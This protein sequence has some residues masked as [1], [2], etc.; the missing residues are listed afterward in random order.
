MTTHLSILVGYHPWNYSF[1]EIGIARNKEV[2]ISPHPYA[3]AFYTSSEFRIDHNKFII[4]PKIGCWAAGGSAAMA[5]GASII[6]YTDFSTSS[7]RA[8][9]EIG[10]GMDIWKV[11]WGYNIPLTNR[12]FKGINTNVASLQLLLGVKTLKETEIKE[13]WD[14]RWRNRNDSLIFFSDTLHVPDTVITKYRL[15]L[16]GGINGWRYHQFGEVGFGYYYEDEDAGLLTYVAEEVM[17]GKQLLTGTKTGAFLHGGHE[18]IFGCGLAVINYTDFSTSSWV[19]RPEMGFHYKAHRIVYGYNYAF[20]K[21]S[22][23][24]VNRN[25][26]SLILCLRVKKLKDRQVVY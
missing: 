14:P 13:D 7:L 3:D 15:M 21:H 24:S 10:M 11:S 4:G 12:S 1:F 20:S 23:P 25:N 5:L 2:A 19:L 17:P 6:D 22:F 18:V 9:P 16:L 26:I 8:R